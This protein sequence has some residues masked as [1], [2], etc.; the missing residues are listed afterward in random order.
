MEF[1]YLTIDELSNHWKCERN[2][3][4]GALG[5]ALTPSVN[6]HTLKA[7]VW[8]GDV[9]TPGLDGTLDYGG[10]H[11][12]DETLFSAATLYVYS[13]PMQRIYEIHNQDGPS[14][15]NLK[16][17]ESMLSDTPDLADGLWYCPIIDEHTQDLIPIEDLVVMRSELH[18]LESRMTLPAG[19]LHHK[20]EHSLVNMLAG[21][22][23]HLMELDGNLGTI[24]NPDIPKLIKKLD[25]YEVGEST[26]RKYIRKAREIWHEDIFEP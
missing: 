23:Q 9:P 25:S 6:I 3:T 1:P 18:E 16:L 24:D 21:A 22:I 2:K 17:S 14:I 20:S 19:P 11:K 7:E 15:K 26:I 5:W 8:T 12:F 13:Y 10:S 4:L